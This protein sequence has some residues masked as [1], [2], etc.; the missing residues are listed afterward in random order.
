VVIVGGGLEGIEALGEILRRYGRSSALGVHLVDAG[1]RFLPESALGIDQ[2]VRSHCETFP[3]RFSF[4]AR[5]REVTAI[6]VLL[7]SGERIPSDLTIWTGGAQAP[8]LLAEAGLCRNP[9]DWAATRR[10]LQAYEHDD[11]F[12]AGDAADLTP[13]LSKQA[14]HAL[15]M[16]EHCAGNVE[17]FLRREPLSSFAPKEKPTLISFGDLDTFLVTSKMTLAG[18]PLAPFKEA[19]FQ[20]MMAKLYRP[21]APDALLG[22]LGRLSRVVRNPILSPL[23]HYRL[24]RELRSLGGVRVLQ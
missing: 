20:L 15:D 10:T 8:G 12:L 1:F 19:I 7:E 2:A 4:D 21:T 6:E 13:R 17:R 11:I 9:G 5:V 24:L 14:Y 16:G 23:S 18:K 22:T 3:A